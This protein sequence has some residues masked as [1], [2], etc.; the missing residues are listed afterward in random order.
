M[1]K[2]LQFVMMPRLEGPLKSATDDA[3]VVAENQELQPVLS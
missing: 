1:L 2:V 3:S